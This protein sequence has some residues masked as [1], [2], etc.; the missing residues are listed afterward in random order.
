MIIRNCKKNERVDLKNF[1][2][3]YW[4]KNH[5]LSKNDKLLDWLFLNNN[6]YNW[7]VGKKDG[8]SNFDAILGYNNTSL[9]DK[10]LVN[11]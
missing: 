1:I 7:M 9:L 4:K 8:E 10:N 6:H 11:K 5:I 2:H 3:T